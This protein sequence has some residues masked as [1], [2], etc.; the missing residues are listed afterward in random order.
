LSSQLEI[1]NQKASDWEPVQESVLSYMEEQ[2]QR[3]N[4]F[5]SQR[6]QFVDR[7][8]KKVINYGQWLMLND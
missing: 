8:Y 3:D 2:T 4:K 7:G 6:G 5:G 1:F